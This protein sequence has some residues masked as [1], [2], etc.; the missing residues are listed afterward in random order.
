M[1]SAWQIWF[2]EQS[3]AALDNGF[4]P[5]DNRNKATVFFENEV[6]IDIYKNQR[7]LW[8]DSEYTGVLSWQFHKKSGLNS[9]DV[10]ASIYRDKEQGKLKDVYLLTP[11]SYMGLVS[12]VHNS[13]FP[14][15]VAVRD[16]LN[17]SGLFPFEL[18]G[19]NNGVKSF[20]NFWMV[21]PSVF[22]DYVS[23]YLIPLYKW[24][25]ETKD[26]ALLDELHKVTKHKCCTPHTFIMEGL[27]QYY[28]AFKGCSFGYIHNEKT[29]LKGYAFGREFTLS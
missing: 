16:I 19:E 14:Q 1:I 24:M 27:F 8:I 10:F 9:S 26:A 23:N 2:D 17:K 4:I 12:V 21:K 29:A 5:Y 7:H 25:K 3:F 13:S 20:C 22:E 6:I 18:T 28:V 15:I 11:K